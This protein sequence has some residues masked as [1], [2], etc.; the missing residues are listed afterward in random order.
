[1]GADAMTSR[2]KQLALDQVKPG[3]VLSDDLIDG[4]GN[5][6]LP[7]GVTLTDA[8]LASLLRHGVAML[9]I[10][11]EALSEADAEAEHEH[12]KKRLAILFRKQNDEEAS[13]LLLEYVKHFRLGT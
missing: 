2:S 1:M 13:A 11:C 5:I 4:H 12:H 8:T 6:L 7:Q 10:L 3:M 9:P